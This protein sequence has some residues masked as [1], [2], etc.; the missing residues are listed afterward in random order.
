[1]R[2]LITDGNERSALATTRSLGRRG[3]QVVVGASEGRCLAG[4]SRYCWRSFT[5]PSPYTHPNEYVSRLL[6]VIRECE[7]SVFFPMSDLALH[8]VA[9]Q[10]SEFD[11][12]VRIP[13]P[14]LEIIHTLTDKCYLM[15]LAETLG[16]PIPETTFVPN[17]EAQEILSSIESFPVVVKPGRSATRINGVWQKTA[18]QYAPDSG[19]LHR[20]YREND[21]LRLPSL[22]QRRVYGEG[23]GIFAL[24]N[25]GKPVALFA[26]RRLREKPPSGGVSVMSESIPLPQPITSYALRLLEHVGWHGVAMV[27]FKLD[28]QSKEPML[29]EVNGRFWG[30]LQLAIDAGLDFPFLLYSLAC[31]GQADPP[32]GNY[33]IGVKLRWLLGDLDHLILRIRRRN[34]KLHLPQSCPSRLKELVDFLR[35]YEHDLHYETL[36]FNDTAPFILELSQYFHMR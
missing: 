3:I 2:V 24:M 34:S 28:E 22:I 1:M 8:L 9:Q 25:H 6:E 21:Y 27:E 16:I 32:I 20:L 33:R 4:V 12:L 35:F 17:A 36:R 30:S 10:F 18:V 5:Y 29:M 23:H 26:H 19:A 14:G 11:P 15:R 7:I 31:R 13:I